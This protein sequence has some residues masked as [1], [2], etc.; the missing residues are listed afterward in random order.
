MSL[1][2]PALGRWFTEHLQV[3]EPVLRSWLETRF[4]AI[5]DIDDVIQEAYIRVLKAH[6][7]R[8]IRQPKAFFFATARNLACNHCRK[9]HLA[10][11]EPLDDSD[12]FAMLDEN[13]DI[14]EVVARNQELEL[15]TQAV[16]SLPERCR[17][18]MTLRNVYG[19]SYREIAEQLRISVRTVEVHIAQGVKRCARYLSKF[20]DR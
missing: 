9:L 19:L 14:A 7:E 5:T 10:L 3:H 4:P 6:T 20:R 15:I 13:V 1:Q 17:Q 16:Q 12:D 8:P 11:I 2:D 18:V